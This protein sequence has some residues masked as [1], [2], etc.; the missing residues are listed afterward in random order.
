[1]W[2]RM[3][4]NRP[5]Q[6]LKI[7]DQKAEKIQEDPW[8]DWLTAEMRAEWAQSSYLYERYNIYIFTIIIIIIIIIIIFFFFF[9]FFFF[10]SHYSPVRT[11]TYMWVHA[12][13]F[14]NTFTNFGDGFFTPKQG[15]EKFHTYMSTN[16]ETSSIACTFSRYPSF[17]LLSVWPHKTI[18]LCYLPSSV[19]SAV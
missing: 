11:V 7:I 6:L 12:G 5:P 1:M 4:S 8:R 18:Y 2:T 13:G 3:P 15:E 10:L 9:F 16:A 19:M 14:K 17:G